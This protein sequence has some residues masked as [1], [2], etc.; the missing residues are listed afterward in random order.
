[1]IPMFRVRASGTCRATVLPTL[2]DLPL[3]MAERAVRVGHLVGVLASLDRRAEAVHGIDELGRELLTHALAA[4]LAGRLDEPADAERHA[5][6]APDLDRD[7]VRG[8]ADAARL[9]LDDRRGV[10]EGSLEDLEPGPVGLGLG[11]GECRPEDPVG[12]VPLAVRHELRGEPRRRP[13]RRDGLV[14]EHPGR[15]CAA[16]HQL[17]PPGRLEAFAPYLLRPCLRSRTPAAS[18]VPRMM[19]YLT[20]GRSRTLPPRTRTTE[21]SWRLWPIPGM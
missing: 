17:S 16:R 15:A 11:A 6:L 3:E 5:A 10:A 20:D 12:Q 21:C 9:D 14:L 7:L 8:A 1:M 2:P 4:A 18:R 19:W 13:V